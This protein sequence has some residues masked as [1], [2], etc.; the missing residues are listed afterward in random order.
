MA[1]LTTEKKREIILQCI[2]EGDWSGWGDQITRDDLME[3]LLFYTNPE[4][5]NGGIKIKKLPKIN[6][7]LCGTATKPHAISL[8]CRAVY[9]LLCAHW[10]SKESLSKGGDGYV[11]YQVINDKLQGNFKHEKGTK[12]GQGY[13]FTSYGVLTKA[14]WDFLK[15]RVNADD[16]TM[17]DGFFMPTDKCLQ[18]LRGQIAVPLRI[19]RLDTDVVRYSRELVYAA[20]VKNVNY[21]QALEIYKTF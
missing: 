18:F 14:P 10:L 17:R 13:S 12:F 2:T 8:T 3:Y 21:K 1:N 19:E 20:S 7:P 6:C 11:H 16:K 9:Y 15:P 5:T 4:I